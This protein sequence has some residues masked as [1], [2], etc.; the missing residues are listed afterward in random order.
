MIRFLITVSRSSPRNLAW[1]QTYPTGQA[2]RYR[3]A[4]ISYASSDRSEVIRRVQ[5]LEALG[6]KYFQDLLDLDPGER[7]EKA[8]Y[9]AID[10]ADLFLLFWSN[11][12]RNSP[13]VRKEIGYA[14][15][16]KEGQDE[17]PPEIIPIVIEGPPAPAPP[18]ELAHLHFSD[19]ILY[20]LPKQKA[21]VNGRKTKCPG[22]ITCP[23]CDGRF[24]TYDKNA[25]DGRKHTRCGTSIELVYSD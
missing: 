9:R 24:A 13:F 11:A 2:S 16:L 7:W 4:F 1:T 5:V 12:A 25:W 20:F 10:D 3:N 21:V 14:I 6:I 18:E 8:I 22:W 17:K 19:R 23:G 15:Q